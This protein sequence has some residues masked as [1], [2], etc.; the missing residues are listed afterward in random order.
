MVSLQ[1]F[2]TFP[3]TSSEPRGFLR[4]KDP[5]WLPGVQ[6]A[7]VGLTS[8]LQ[9]HTASPPTHLFAVPQPGPSWL[10]LHT[11]AQAAPSAFQ[12]LP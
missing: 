1:T 2:Q 10:T 9:P 6:G 5:N 3:V 4:W 11:F 7:V 12:F 8:G